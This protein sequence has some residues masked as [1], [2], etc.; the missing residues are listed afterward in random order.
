MLSDELLQVIKGI[1][2]RGRMALAIT[3]LEQTAKS[4][5]VVSTELDE[6]ITYSWS[7]TSTHY[8]NEWDARFP[9]YVWD[10]IELMETHPLLHLKRDT[11]FSDKSRS[12]LRLP[13]PVL[14]ICDVIW[15]E[16]GRSNLYGAVVGYSEETFIGTVKVLKFLEA[17]NLPLPNLNSFTKS[18]FFENGGWG[19]K[20]NRDFFS[21][22]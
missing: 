4:Y 16:I 1:S 11:S 7:F 10:A 9:K 18:A 17:L 5:S 14:I 6:V 8:L 13:L 22:T 2:I 15:Q 19:L 20:V 12:F 3:C 21:L